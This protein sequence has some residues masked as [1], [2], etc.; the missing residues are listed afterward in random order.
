MRAAGLALKCY[1]Y[2]IGGHPIL[3][4][5]YT[6]FETEARD[7]IAV[8]RDARGWAKMLDG[9][10]REEA[11]RPERAERRRALARANTYA[12]RITLQREALAGHDRT[13]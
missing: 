5:P 7:L 12:D 1:E 13:T 6:D 11:E 8:G 2:C 10:L 3:A 4:T 9:L